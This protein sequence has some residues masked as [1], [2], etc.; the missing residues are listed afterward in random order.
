M[1]FVLKFL[2]AN[3]LSSIYCPKKYLNSGCVGGS[4][5]NTV[6]ADFSLASC[7]W[8]CDADSEC[9][10]WTMDWVDGSCVLYDECTQDDSLLVDDQP[11]SKPKMDFYAKEDCG[12]CD[13]FE[14]DMSFLPYADQSLTGT[15]QNE[16]EHNGHAYFKHIE[17]ERYMFIEGKSQK[18]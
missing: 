3:G 7:Y 4:V 18:S 9:V 14:L 8:A 1:R 11:D 5:L 2:V 15:W 10:G 16:G 17:D 13:Q 12:S 6:N